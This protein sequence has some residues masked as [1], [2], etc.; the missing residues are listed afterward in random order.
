MVVQSL[1]GS[2]ISTKAKVY[3]PICP[4]RKEERQQKLDLLNA[5]PG[6][7]HVLTHTRIHESSNSHLLLYYTGLMSEILNYV[8]NI[9]RLLTP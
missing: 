9:L 4:R 1:G 5:G 6:H 8:L 3:L 7:T 2:S